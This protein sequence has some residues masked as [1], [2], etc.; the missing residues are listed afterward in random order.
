METSSRKQDI[1]H[2]I[3]HTII[4]KRDK[5]LVTATC[6]GDTQSFAK[7]V[8]FYRRKVHALGF[9]FFH[10]ETDTE[11]FVQEVF[12][13]VYTSL[14]TFRGESLFSTWLMR[15]AYNL[16]VNSVKRRKEYV[17]LN[18]EIEILDTDFGPEDSQL[19]KLTAES[20]REAINELPERYGL[21]LDMY[22]F[23]DM[24]Y[25]EISEVTELPVNTIKSHIFRA[26]KILRDKLAEIL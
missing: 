2:S 5:I 19:R 10:N 16:A 6:D 17:P 26:K 23:Y 11:D 4:E 22:F 8:G 24:P 15:I 3:E 9:S 20:V 21:C 14:K 1:K 7:L 18:D 12:I 25:N 13:K